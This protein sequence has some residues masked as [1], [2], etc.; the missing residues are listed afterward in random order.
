MGDSGRYDTQALAGPAPA[1]PPAERAA[2]HAGAGGAPADPEPRLPARGFAW[3]VC[4][5]LAYVI[6]LAWIALAIWASLNLPS[7]AQSAGALGDLTAPNAPAIAA[8]RLDARLFGVPAISRVAVVQ[9]APG[10]LSSPVLQ[11]TAAQA[12]ALDQHR[13]ATVPPGLLGALPIVDQP[14]LVPASRQARTTAITYLVFDPALD[15]EVQ[16]AGARQ[17]ADQLAR[18]PGSS[19]VGVTGVVPAR[20][21]QGT[22]ILSR[23]TLI[24]VATVVLIALVVGLTFRSIGAPLVTLGAGIVAY[25]VAA[26]VVAWFGQ[27]TG[28]SAPQELQPLMIVLLLGIVTDYSIFFLSGFRRHLRAG[29]GRKAAARATTSEFVPT[30]LAAGIMVAAAT[31]CLLVASLTFFRALGPGMALTVLI[32]LGVAITFVPAVLAVFGRLVFAPGTR[33]FEGPTTRGEIAAVTSQ[34][35]AGPF[36]RFASRRPVGVIVTIVGVALL[37]VASTGVARTHLGF[38]L[39]GGLPSSSEAAR[40]AAAASAGF[41][42]GILSPTEIIVQKPALAAQRGALLA[43]ESQ[44]ARRPGVAGVVGPR[45]QY[46][47]AAAG[48]AAPT[49]SGAAIAG[50]GSAARF[51]VI[52]NADPLGSRGIGWYNDLRAALPSLLARSGLGGAR[53]SYAGDTALAQQTLTR[54]VADLRRVGIAVIVVDLVLLALFL[55]ALVA[56]LYLLAASILALTASFGLTVY[57]F[58]DLFHQQDI[59]YYVPFAAAVLLISLGSDYNIFLVSR[60]WDRARVRPLHQAVEEAAPRATRAISVA[61][62]ALGLSF[63]LLALIDLQAFRQLAFLLLVGVLIDSFFVRSLLVPALVTA[64]GRSSA[65]PGS[66][67]AHPVGAAQVDDQEEGDEAAADQRAA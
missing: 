63:A 7:I 56:P 30:I 44:L 11:A 48:G 61:A 1:A 66:L 20:L 51:L 64:F 24:E 46:L 59:V 34:P 50:D 18:T 12:A 40:A 33:Q 62:L 22:A 38:G 58:Q 28:T 29:A 10:G 8:Q 6:P 36:A 65:W 45:E 32:G 43:L 5:P 47:G 14:G 16:V 53:V 60:I 54:T 57:I 13:A 23:L 15:W 19:V 31:A 26:H 52:L 25:V 42:P 39:T 67:P 55:R 41:A 4:G 17:Y 21:E 9:H 27:R 3:V 35:S 2:D 49:G 37:V